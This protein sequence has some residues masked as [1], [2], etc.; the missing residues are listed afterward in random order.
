[1]RRSLHADDA[2]YV[3]RLAWAEVSECFW[4]GEG[5]QVDAA[6]AVVVMG[7]FNNVSPVDRPWHDS[8][9]LLQTMAEVRRPRTPHDQCCQ[10]NSDRSAAP[11]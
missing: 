8:S 7:D 10:A 6:E 9:G 3:I 2:V 4:G 1:M 5:E 11:G